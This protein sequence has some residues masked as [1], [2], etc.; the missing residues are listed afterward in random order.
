MYVLAFLGLLPTLSH[1]YLHYWLQALPW[2]CLLT[3]VG[4]FWLVDSVI[5]WERVTRANVHR[6]IAISALLGLIIGV[7][8]TRNEIASRVASASVAARKQNAVVSWISRKV[9]ASAMLLVGPANPEYYFLANHMPSTKYVYLLS[10]DTSLYPTAES[11]VAAGRF[12]YIVWNPGYGGERLR[13]P[14]DVRSNS[15]P[16]SRSL[17]LSR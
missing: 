8:G 15:H 9:P 12:Q 10:V 5:Q 11:Q 1:D 14:A 13:V 6:A 3:S 17:E 2:A 7:V 16:L 4:V